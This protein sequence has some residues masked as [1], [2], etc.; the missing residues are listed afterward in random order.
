M[1]VASQS[2][3]TSFS[4]P[5]ST[6]P[7]SASNGNFQLFLS[8]FYSLLESLIEQL[9]KPESQSQ[10]I[11]LLNEVVDFYWPEISEVSNKM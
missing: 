6:Q 7:S 3:N 5:G 9:D 1:K 4:L 10:A 11:R 2:I 8:H